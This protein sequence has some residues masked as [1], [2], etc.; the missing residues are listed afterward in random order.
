MEERGSVYAVGTGGSGQLGQG[1]LEPRNVFTV[2]PKAQGASVCFVSTGYDM[3]FA[4]TEDHEVMVWGGSGVGPAGIAPVPVEEQG[5]NHEH[6]FM[7]PRIVDKLTV[8]FPPLV[9]LHRCA[10]PLCFTARLHRSAAPACPR[11]LAMPRHHR[12]HTHARGRALARVGH[13]RARR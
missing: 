6:R 10:S 12:P 5:V 2:I 3:V 9:V 13:Y 8:S 11:C 7:E 4:V 1:D